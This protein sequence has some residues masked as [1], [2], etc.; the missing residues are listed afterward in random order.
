MDQKYSSASSFES[1]ELQLNSAG[2]EFLRETAKWANF[3]A[4]IGYIFLGLLVLGALMFFAMGS[5]MSSLSGMGAFGAL[6][7]GFVG[8]IYIIM[9]LIYYFPITYL[10]R[11]ASRTKRALSE[12]NTESLTEALENLKSH[13]KFI[14][15]VTLIFLS[16]YALIIVF[17]VIG[18]I[19]AA[20]A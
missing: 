2:K 3:L 15:I 12:N 18:A 6:G 9:A 5:M 10:Y 14:G 16:L 13:Y 20:A 8:V 11:F 17:G 7:G 19:A 1:F 4:I